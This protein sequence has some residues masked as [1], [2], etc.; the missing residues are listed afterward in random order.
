MTI[1]N[2]AIFNTRVQELL[3][4]GATTSIISFDLARRLKLSLN[5]KDKLRILGEIEGIAIDGSGSA[6]EVW[7]RA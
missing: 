2:G 7:D 4:P 1:V 3:D 6:T 5:H